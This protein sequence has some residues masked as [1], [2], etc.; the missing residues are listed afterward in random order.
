MSTLPLQRL[1]AL[2][3]RL[4]DA[5]L[6]SSKN[7]LGK[8]EGE[9]HFRRQYHPSLSPPGW[10]LG[11]CVYVEC[12]WVRSNL[13]GDS[14]LERRLRNFYVPELV[15]KENRGKFLPAQDELI[16]WADRLMEE[17]R[18]MLESPSVKAASDRMLE[19]DYLVHFLIHHH[20]QHLEIVSMANVARHAASAWN[21][22][23]VIEELSPCDP[24]MPAQRLDFGCY[25]VGGGP[26]F[27]YDNELP[28][29]TVELRALDIA[30]R[31]V[32]NA[33]YLE[34][35]RDGGYR[36]RE[37]WSAGGWMWLTRQKVSCPGRWRQ[38]MSGLWFE[39]NFDGP[40]D[41]EAKASVTGITRFEA[42]AFAAWAGRRLP[43]EFEWE[44]AARAGTLDGVGE[45]WEWCANTFH[46]YPGF[47]AHP[48]REYSVPWFDHRHFVLRG[49]CTHSAVEIKRPGFRN[50]YLADADYLFA[51]IRLAK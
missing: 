45:V 50:Y 47:R 15:P 14:K 2:Q 8:I 33:E 46:P 22:Y 27:S 35:I 34:F 4:M 39:I 40:S 20:A 23:R 49:G 29:Q 11:H 17:H 3:M 9:E 42:G 48:Y 6:L 32:T 25:H 38:D 18:V 26:E 30:S 31:P 7:C 51:G 37:W 44:A 24:S 28:R 12:L 10:H 19:N 16:G 1:E 21:D 36:T 5:V 41:L 13:C 43:H